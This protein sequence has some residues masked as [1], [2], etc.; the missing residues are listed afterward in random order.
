MERCYQEKW[1]CLWVVLSRKIQ[2]SQSSWEGKV[3]YLQKYG[4]CQGA[5]QSNVSPNGK[6]R[7]ALIYGNRHV[8]ASI[9]VQMVKNPPAMQET[10][11]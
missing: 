7:E 4:E 6:I 1:V 9:V 11:V 2:P 8:E 3:Y 5:F 10:G